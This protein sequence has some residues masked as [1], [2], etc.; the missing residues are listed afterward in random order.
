MRPFLAR[1]FQRSAFL[2]G[3]FAP[4]V[5]EDEKPDVVVEEMIERVLSRPGF[6]PESELAASTPTTASGG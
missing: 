3:T 4:E 6:L 2:W 1:H 5:I